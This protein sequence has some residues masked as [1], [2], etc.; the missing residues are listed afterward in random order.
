M[1]TEYA[2]QFA[3]SDALNAA[4]GADLL[5]NPNNYFIRVPDIPEN[6]DAKKGAQPKVIVVGIKNA[7]ANRVDCPYV[8]YQGMYYPVVK[9]AVNQAWDTSDGYWQS[10]I[11]GI[12]WLA[13]AYGIGTGLY[14]AVDWLSTAATVPSAG[15]TVATAVDTTTPIEI[16][17]PAESFPVSMP[18]PAQWEPLPSDSLA[19]TNTL[20]NSPVD[21]NAPGDPYVSTPTVP[22]LPQ[23]QIPASA[24]NTPTVP[25]SPDAPFP[26]PTLHDVPLTLPDLPSLPGAPAF[27]V[28]VASDGNTLAQITSA[29]STLAKIL[30][31]IATI[32]GITSG[33]P[34][35]SSN[36]VRVIGQ[37]N[38]SFF[39]SGPGGS[40]YVDSNGNVISS[41][42]LSFGA[43]IIPG[44]SNGVLIAGGLLALLALKG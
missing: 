6:A 10:T 30:A 41:P 4:Y 40:R 43:P 42:G 17:A 15:S 19:T 38:G 37:P 35:T 5:A 13:T 28:P 21:Y 3:G 2:W 44:V 9:N 27:N 26:S 18:E 20:V 29:G 39:V 33:R 16:S 1:H 25:S 36:P 14:N 31:P 12:S 7:N 24:P 34:I 8:L 11:E 32:I 23:V 22:D